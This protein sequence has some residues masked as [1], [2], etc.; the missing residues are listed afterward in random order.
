MNPTNPDPGLP[1]TDGVI[2]CAA[3]EAGRRV[4]SL[5]LDE[6]A[7]YLASHPDGFVWAGLYE[8]SD[9]VLRAVQRQFHL[10]DLAIEDAYRAHQRP[11]LEQYEH[12]LF[13]VLR[14]VQFAGQ[15]EHLDFGETHVFIGDRFVVSVRHGS[16]RSHVGLRARSES[17]P[18][19]LAKGPGY[20]LYALMDF[21]VDQYFPVIDSMSERLGDLEEAIFEQQV[22]RNTTGAIYHLKRDLLAVRRAVSPLI[23]VCNRLVRFDSPLLPEDTRVYFRDVYDHVVRLNE[24]VDTQRELLT[25]AL[26]ANLSLISIAQNEHMKRLAAWAAIIAI[27]TMVAGIYGMNFSHM[28][29]LRWAYGYPLSLGLMV[30]ACLGLFFGFRRAGWL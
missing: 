15:D 8:P 10:H 5:R 20:V 4:S 29:E 28:P 30:I 2:D 18:H 27:P 14:T 1:P 13:A 22:T 11:K 9:D 19:L 3:Y 7:V 26:E 6:L 12:T 25:T 16:L 23:D 17:T 24:M 21:I